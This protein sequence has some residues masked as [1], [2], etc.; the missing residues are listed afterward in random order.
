MNGATLVV[1]RCIYWS[2]NLGYRVD[3]WFK[4]K[5]HIVGDK[6]RETKSIAGRA[7]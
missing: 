1:G 5:T 3:A 7:G 6:Y 2:L 4:T